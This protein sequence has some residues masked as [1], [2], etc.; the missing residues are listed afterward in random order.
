[1]S[2]VYIVQFHDG[3]VKIG[4]SGKA[5]TRFKALTRKVGVVDVLALTP[6]DK[7]TEKLL[8]E[9]FSTYN[10]PPDEAM[11]KGA[12]LGEYFFPADEILEYAEE[13]SIH[14]ELQSEVLEY[15]KYLA[16]TKRD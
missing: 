2:S 10:L 14:P 15:Y 12:G 6:G 4:Y 7:V 13:L 16:Y 11:P 3:R 8:Q 9:K 1:M 5:S